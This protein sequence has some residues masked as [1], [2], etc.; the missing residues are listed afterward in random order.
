MVL[1]VGG[2]DGWHA[3]GSCLGEGVDGWGFKM[4][5]EMGR[6]GLLLLSL[7]EGLRGELKRG[8]ELLEDEGEDEASLAI[9][10]SFQ[11]GCSVAEILGWRRKKGKGIFVL[12]CFV[13]LE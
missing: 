12:F 10:K 1:F 6:L 5:E 8:G 2:R 3:R 11:L 13:S 4:G 7:F 9:K